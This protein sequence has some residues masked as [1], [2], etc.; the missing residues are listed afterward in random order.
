M[1]LATLII[2]MPARLANKSFIRK[3]STLLTIFQSQFS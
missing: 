3:I 2:K 1:P